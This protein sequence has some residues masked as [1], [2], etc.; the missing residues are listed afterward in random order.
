MKKITS[1][2]YAKLN[3]FLDI[4]SKYENG[5]HELKTVMQ[6]INLYDEIS[7]ELNESK[8][9][10]TCS[11]NSIPTDNKNTCYKALNILRKRYNIKS[12]ASIHITKNIPSEAGMGGG[13]S[14]A[15]TVI[16]LIDKLWNLKLTEDNM[17]CIGKEIGADVPFCL[18]GGT[19]L[20]EGIGEKITKLSPFVWDN[21]VIV[22][23]NFSICTKKA[24]DNLTE[25]DYN[26][27]CDNKIVDFIQKNDYLQVCK[28]LHNTL[29]VVSQRIFPEINIIKGELCKY[30]AINSIMTGSGSAV[31]GLYNSLYAA[32][33]AYLFLKKKYKKVYIT[34]TVRACN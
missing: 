20:C 25:K 31:Y 29:E 19:C 3:L 32:Q 12:Y 27:C 34:N 15:A 24:Y 1:K 16:K 26:L 6:E 17:K 7:V 21:I 14:D 10:I 9:I 5:Y 30:G 2:A 13:S 33:K 28:N 4:C 22:K 11:D 8:D 18:N 23:P